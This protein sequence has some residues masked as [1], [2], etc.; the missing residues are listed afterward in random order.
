M[1]AGVHPATAITSSSVNLRRLYWVGPATVA[2]AVLAVAIVQR[3]AV[4]LLHPLPPA[5]KFPMLSA[6]P[7]IFTAVLVM[8]AVIVFAVVGDSASDP[9]RTFRRVALAVLAFSFAPNVVAAVS[10]G[11]GSWRPAAALA[12]MHVA[13]WAVTVTMPIGLTTVQP[14]GH[15]I[16]RSA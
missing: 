1:E 12:M 16:R 11:E 7:L 15:G 3:V 9:V 8:A 10:W 6:E 4:A 2:A 5:F 13:A 14:V